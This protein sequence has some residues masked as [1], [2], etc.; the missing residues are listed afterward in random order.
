[1]SKNYT[2][3]GTAANVELGKGNSRIK[4]SGGLI[5]ARN[6]ADGAFVEGQGADATVDDSWITLRQLNAATLGLKWKEP[7]DA[8][9]IVAGTLATDFDNSKVIDGYTLV[10]GNRILVKNQAS[11][12]ENGIYIVAASGPPT[13]AADMAAGT[14]AANAAMF[15]EQG[16]TLADTAWVCTDDTGSDV[17]G[18]DVLAFIQFASVVAGIT[19]I[20]LG[21]AAT[22]ATPIISGTGPTA[23]LRGFIGE[24]GVLT[25]ALSTDDIIYSLDALGV[26]TGKI[27]DD[28]IT[29]A[30][31]DQGV[32][33]LYRILSTVAA[34]WPAAPGDNTTNIGAVLP[35]GAIVLGGRV[36]VLTA[37][38]NTPLL[39]VGISATPDAVQANSEIDLETADTY[40]SDRGSSQSA[41]Q[42]IVT[43]ETQATQPTVG[44]CQVQ[45][46]FVNP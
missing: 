8:A 14:G 7:V 24:S 31:L 29:E 26:D 19:T 28:A 30:K 13:R 42:L 27:A 4:E 1:M 23:T 36:I 16:T 18:T 39:D 15:V 17:V 6:N 2:L 33:N 44:A 32:A 38:D 5:Q 43:R 3:T 12:I 45:V 20:A 35:T 10:T 34:D 25:A 41:S 9:T 40:V 22:G 37:F 21:G 11:G 46:T